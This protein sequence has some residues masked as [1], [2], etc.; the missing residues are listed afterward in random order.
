MLFASCITHP[1]FTRNDIRICQADDFTGY[2]VPDGVGS[3][4]TLYVDKGKLNAKEYRVEISKWFGRT[5]VKGEG[6]DRT[7]CTLT[8]YSNPAERDIAEGVDFQKPRFAVDTTLDVMY[9]RA[10]GLWT[11]YPYDNSIDYGTMVRNKVEELWDNELDELPLRLDVY[12][13]EDEGNHLRP[14]LVMIHEGAFFAGDKADDASRRWCE[15]FAACGYVAVSVN[16]RMG[17]NLISISVP[18]AAYCALQDVN[19]AI[20]YMLAHQVN[21]KIDPDKI[22]LAGCSAGAILALNTAFLNDLNLPESLRSVA[23]EQGPLTAVPVFPAYD[24]PFSI[25]AIGNMWGAVLDSEVLKS[26][27]TSIISFHSIYDPIVPYGRGYPFES[28]AKELLKKV[29]AGS[30][31]GSFLVQ[32]FVPLVYGSSCVDSLAQKCGKRT[33]IYPSEIHKHTLVRNDLTGQLNELH[34]EFF[35]KMNKFFVKE[36]IGQVV[37][38]RQ[39]NSDARIIY[40]EYSDNIRECSW[41]V[42]D[43]FITEL[44]NPTRVRVLLYGNPPEHLITVKGVYTSGIAFEETIPIEML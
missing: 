23:Q 26:S 39:D 17:F 43:G 33:E 9:G 30:N 32:K 42:Q 8:H 36:M 40:L 1:D 19:A 2:F 38:L 34:K 10:V 22:F 15:M 25:R 24:K 31:I 11:S 6:L 27:S 35:D 28:L 13:P 18:E 3:E 41:S 14:L 29:P 37:S 20:R 5:L 4:G 16:Y 12:A 7:R 44:L 21:Y